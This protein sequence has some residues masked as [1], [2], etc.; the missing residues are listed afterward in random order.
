MKISIAATNPCHLFPMAREL[1]GLD[2]LGCYYSGY[3]KWKLDAGNGLSIRTHS[4]R[5]NVVYGLLKFAPE[6]FRPSAR[7][8][9]LWQDRGFDRWVGRHLAACDFIHGMPGQCLETFRAAKRLGI[10]TVLNH[11]TGPVREWVR[12]MEPEY[13]RVGL[14]VTD[15]CPCDDAYL[16]R[17]ESEYAL[18]DWHCAAST[19]V[20]EQLVA[21]GIP[22]ERIWLVPYGADLQIFHPQGAALPGEFR[23]VFAGQ[24]C[25]R[26]GIKTL[27]DALTLAGRPEWRADFFG[28]VSSEMKVDLA[29]Y[30][31]L[32]PL[33]FHGPVSQ[34]ELAGAFRRGSVLVL[35]S[36]EEGFGLVVPQALNCGLPAIVSDHVGGK[37]LIRPGENGAIVPVGDA[38]ALTAELIRW[39]EQPRRVHE[40]FGWTA[41]ARTLIACSQAH[42]A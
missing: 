33:T 2:A 19:V 6:R 27:L 30:R 21:V 8:L 5:T 9:F 41:P 23:L 12:T 25:L 7:S 37:D 15:A 34:T 18:A 31:G 26:K 1:A 10:M 36:L 20:R 16:A 14:R 28:M 29:A 40:Q 13:A 11:A 4:L 42:C 39:A 17:E 35:P 32:T 24:V 38:A 3:P 22:R